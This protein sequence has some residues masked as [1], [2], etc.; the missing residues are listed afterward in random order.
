[1]HFARR[2][3]C[4]HP[5]T[6]YFFNGKVAFAN[7]FNSSTK[8]IELFSICNKKMYLYEERHPNSVWRKQRRIACAWPNARKERKT[9]ISEL[10]E[11]ITISRSVFIWDFLI[12]LFIL[13]SPSPLEIKTMYSAGS[14]SGMFAADTNITWSANFHA[15]VTDQWK[16]NSWMH[17]N[18]LFFVFVFGKWKNEFKKSHLQSFGKLHFTW[19]LDFFERWI[20]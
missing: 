10:T 16:L 7:I 15:K 14:R 19:F 6:R 5:G 12:F 4:Y 8:W 18:S 11:N 9:M 17:F 13:H 3:Y 2:C 1:M 20:P